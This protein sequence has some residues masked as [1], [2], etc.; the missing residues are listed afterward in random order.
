MLIEYLNLSG[1]FNSYITK[2][3]FWGDGNFSQIY[4]PQK[5]S[6]TFGAKKGKLGDP[7]IVTLN[8][9]REN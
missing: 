7:V 4:H 2:F 8:R 5:L 9:L 1:Y 3:S 6:N